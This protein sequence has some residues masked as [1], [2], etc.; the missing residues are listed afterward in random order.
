VG[1]PDFCNVLK[2]V[3]HKQDSTEQMASDATTTTVEDLRRMWA[4]ADA[5]LRRHVERFDA[6]VQGGDAWKARRL[7]TV[8]GSELSSLLGEN[9]YSSELN[10]LARKLGIDRSDP[11][12]A[13]WWG[14]MMEPV[15]ERLVELQCG[16]RAHGTGIHMHLPDLIEGHANSP[17]GFCV[18]A[19][20]DGD[21]PGT[22]EL[23]RGLDDPRVAAAPDR[24]VVLPALLELK[25]PYSRIPDGRKMPKHYSAQVQSGMALSHPAVSV[26]LFCEVVYRM[27][28]MMQLGTDDTYC[29]G[30]HEKDVTRKDTPVWDGALAWGLV[31]V[32]APATAAAAARSARGVAPHRPMQH[33][34]A[35]SFFA[36]AHARALGF[37]PSESDRGEEI[38][39]LAE[40]ADADPRVFNQ[41][42]GYVDRRV[43]AVAHSP[44]AG[45][46][47]DPDA[48]LEAFMGGAAAAAPP[49]TYLMGYL[50]WKVFR[51]H[52]YVVQPEEGFLDSIR[53]PVEEFMARVRELSAAADV[54][55]A[56]LRHC[57][58]V[59]GG[60][61]AQRRRAAVAECVGADAMSRLFADARAEPAQKGA[62]S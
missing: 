48:S 49:G 31:A 57:A 56:Y 34:E 39:D 51:A 46:E 40:L 8:G 30:Y 54:R 15:S 43:A 1:R 35:V 28:T 19:L 61:Q 18:I 17:D 58:S 45:P 41:L 33:A 26:G 25:A 50:P 2:N 13:C 60:A 62:G 6:G 27:C 21:E 55:D 5:G 53:G 12:E 7:Q 16:T 59:G 38:A 32:Y 20:V 11:G 24:A 22:L 4:A 44:I 14:T 37:V 42:L 29:T 52:Y 36:R 10:L 3:A 9:P 23:A 47:G